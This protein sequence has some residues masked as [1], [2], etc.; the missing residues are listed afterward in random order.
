MRW[1][2]S[3]L[4]GALV[5]GVIQPC[6]TGA[7][8]GD[9]GPLIDRIRSA[10]VEIAGK[11]ESFTL[12][13]FDHCTLE[14][15]KDDTVDGRFRLLFKQWTDAGSWNEKRTATYADGVLTLNKAIDLLDGTDG[16]YR[17]L[18]AVRAN[19]REF[20][21]SDVNAKELTDVDQLKRG[22]AYTR[23]R[24]KVHARVRRSNPLRR[25]AQ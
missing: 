2:F 22:F 8:P 19:G 12:Q 16:P 20:L 3:I 15:R 21:I 9:D 11:W 6:Q 24:P 18:Y 7:N 25:T 17:V 1:P 13:H 4:C 10:D 23:S 14:I 5:V